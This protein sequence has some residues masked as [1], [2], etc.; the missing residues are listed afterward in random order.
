MRIIS[1]WN[2]K[3][4]QKKG[5]TFYT[6]ENHPGGRFT[7]SFL[8]FPLNS[9]IFVTN[10]TIKSF[11]DHGHEIWV[12]G[13]SNPLYHRNPIKSEVPQKFSM[14]HLFEAKWLTFWWTYKDLYPERTY[15]RF[16][17]QETDKSG[18][19]PDIRNL[20]K[21]ES[22][23]VEFRIISPSEFYAGIRFNIHKRT[24]GLNLS[25]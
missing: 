18:S 22:V 4:N 12:L 7:A 25:I 8:I 16:Y 5:G 21:I 17:C 10:C 14:D 1:W 23:K 6:P 19:T 2:L 13:D 11:A 24:S 9:G 15:F 3:K 20:V